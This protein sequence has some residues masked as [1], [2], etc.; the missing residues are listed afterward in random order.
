VIVG[1]A[2]ARQFAEPHPAGLVFQFLSQQSNRS[3]VSRK[4]EGADVL[5]G[6]AE[7]PEKRCVGDLRRDLP[8]DLLVLCDDVASAAAIVA[9]PLIVS[10]EYRRVVGL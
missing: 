9:K 5:I 1:G 8:F 2:G 7:D 10:S 6:S 4:R 3:V